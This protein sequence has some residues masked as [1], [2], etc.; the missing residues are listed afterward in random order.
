MRDTKLYKTL[1]QLSNP[2]LNRLH[3]FII[4][5]YFN[6]NEAIIKLF[7]WIKNDLKVKNDKE[8]TKEFLWSTSF[9]SVK[10]NDGRFRKLQSDLLKLIEEYYAQQAFESNPVHKAHF[11]LESLSDKKIESLESTAIKSAM[12]FAD[13]QILK[14][15]SYYHM[16]YE[17]EQSIYILNRNKAERSSKTN[18]ENIVS[19]LDLFFLAEKLRYFSSILTHQHFAAVNYKMLFIDEIIEH[20]KTN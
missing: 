1:I 7:E 6:R 2:E 12:Q 8:I 17:I 19:N 4:S 20:V 11:L 3:R 10:F 15:A 5:P 16:K 14:P 18:I 9:G 13:Q